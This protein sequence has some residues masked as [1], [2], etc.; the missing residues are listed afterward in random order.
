MGAVTIANAYEG[1]IYSTYNND[2]KTGDQSIPFD[3]K[4]HMITLPD[5]TD[6]GDTT[7]VDLWQECGMKRLLGIKGF[8]HTTNNSVVVTEN[9]TC[10]VNNGV[11]TITVPAG[12]DNDLRVYML[13]GI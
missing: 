12:S 5:D 3:L 4:C 8:K 7:T 11:L 9:P 10:T 2:L 13:F 6:A 1:A